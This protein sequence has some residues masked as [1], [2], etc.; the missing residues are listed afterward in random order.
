MSK[1]V[2]LGMRTAGGTVGTEHDPGDAEAELPPHPRCVD[3]ATPGALTSR[4]GVPPLTVL[5]LPRLSGRRTAAHSSCASR[6]W[7]KNADRG[8]LPAF[9]AGL[10]MLRRRAA[11]PHEGR[12]I[13]P[14]EA[15]AKGVEVQG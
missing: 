15:D 3:S 7:I 12:V 10:H 8:D 14:G 13:H 1:V 4:S 9:A 6:S 11:E 5:R 2:L